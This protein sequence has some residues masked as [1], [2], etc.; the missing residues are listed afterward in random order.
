MP[1]APHKSDGR[2]AAVL[3]VADALGGKQF[4]GEALRQMRSAGTLA[5][6]EAGLAMEIAQGAVRHALTIDHVL[7]QLARY[8]RRRTT[9]TL[10]AILA[11]AAYQII[12]M[13]RIPVFAAVDQ[14]VTL[15]R[16]QV[17]GR[18]SGMVNAIL[19]RLSGAV[20]ERSTT[21]QRL[22]P[23]HI[24]VGWDRACTFHTAILPP[25]QDDDAHSAH[26]AAATGQHLDQYRALVARHGPVAAEAISWASQAVPV[27]VLQRNPLR[28]TPDAFAHCFQPDS[29]TAAEFTPVAAFLPA[30]APV[31]D[32]PA[33]AGGLVYVQDT[34]AHRAA[35]AVGVLPGERILDLCAAPGGKSLALAIAANDRATIIACDPDADR[36]GRVDANVARLGLASIR[37]RHLP[38]PEALGTLPRFDAILVDAPCSNTGVIAKR[39]EAR[40][41]FTPPK[42]AA[43]VQTQHALL[44]RAAICATPG[45][46][47]VY[48]TCSIEPAENEQLVAAF[49]AAHPAWRLDAEETTLPAWGPRLSDWRDGGYFA[50]LTHTGPT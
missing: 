9:P 14:A 3:A 6:R 18:A 17:P 20:L 5:G 43:L 28:A 30:S 16:R 12:W 29:D 10:R 49:L 26:L 32:S 7:A 19:R 34:T 22:N 4:A 24:R 42:L 45:G 8:D 37:T 48:S 25:P 15:A 40:L 31:M 50:R 2:T 27:T 47:I 41:G 11:T 44:N 36:L 46:R 23:H 21:W 38:D 13:S 35:L 39:P 1:P 33:F